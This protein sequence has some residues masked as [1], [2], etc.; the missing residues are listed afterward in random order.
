MILAVF[1]KG[2]I[3]VV[4][5]ELDFVNYSLSFDEVRTLVPFGADIDKRYKYIKIS[6]KLHCLF[7][8][9]IGSLPLLLAVTIMLS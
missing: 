6:D 1:C 7:A 2:D 8:F 5:F 3:K 4:K 9:R